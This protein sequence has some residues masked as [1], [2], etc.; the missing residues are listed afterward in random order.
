MFFKLLKPGKTALGLSRS[1][2]FRKHIIVN[3]LHITDV[4]F[5]LLTF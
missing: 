2:M 5:K 3:R 1:G 4:F